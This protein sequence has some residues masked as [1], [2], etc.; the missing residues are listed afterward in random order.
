[1]NLEHKLQGVLEM[2]A[3]VKE[4]VA[5]RR[6]SA[7]FDEG[8]M[9]QFD[10]LVKSE[11]GLAEVVTAYGTV[12]GLPVY[13]FAQ[14]G[15]VAG[16]A[17]SKA[18]AGKIKKVYDFAAKT[19]APVVGIYDSQGARLKEGGEIL[20]AY[21]DMLLWSSSLSGVVPQIS[22]IAG[23]CLGT[24]A[25]IAAS[26]DIVIAAQGTDFGI[27]TNGSEKK[28][29]YV[30]DSVHILAQSVEDALQQTRKV[31][32]MLPSNNLAVV[33]KTDYAEPI[34]TGEELNEVSAAVGTDTRIISYITTG[35]IDAGSL[36]D[37]Q[38]KYG[39]SVL[40]GLATIEGNTVGIVASRSRNDRGKI[41][42]D[43]ASKAARFV[44]F[45]DAFSIPLVSL[46]DTYGFESV[47]DA[48]KVAHA[49]A[50]AT[51]VKLAVIVGSVYGS[52]FVSMAGRAANADLTVAW[53]NAV[54]APLAPETYSAI[55]Y[56][57]RLKGVE[58]PA[59]KRAEIVQEYK[60]TLASPAAS[61]ADGYV[62]DVIAPADTRAV[63]AAALDMLASKKVTRLP[64]KHSNIQ[65]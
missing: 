21:G 36:L 15:D 41:D 57:D 10:T 35:I 12:E 17:I 54:I 51:T 58:N 33:P 5:Y 40:T 61:A 11:G 50:E 55:M 56:S 27:E 23:T 22:V 32:T 42:A 65:L 45:C 26:A 24:N 28:V 63:V 62:D 3:A 34:V 59:E 52:A 64:K 25:L 6:L 31:I 30:A 29:E 49:Y 47:R 16:G 8:S 9:V 60:D 43:S 19:G 46:V 13:A 48:A 38:P 1:M 18:Q 4:T 7:L 37:L 20:A 14:D 2:K 39:R 44:R 53:P